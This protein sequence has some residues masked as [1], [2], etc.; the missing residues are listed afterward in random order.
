MLHIAHIDFHHEV[1]VTRSVVAFCHLVDTTH[2]LHE[3]ATEAAAV[4]FQ[5]DVAESDD[6]VAHAFGIHHSHI[7]SI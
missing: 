6:G 4:L 5:L 2:C 7:V 1:V 3:S